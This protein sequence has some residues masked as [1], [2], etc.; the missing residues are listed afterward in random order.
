MPVFLWESATRSFGASP[1]F[2]TPFQCE[3]LLDFQR[4][5]WAFNGDVLIFDLRCC[6]HDQVCKLAERCVRGGCEFN[7]NVVLV[8]RNGDRV[9]RGDACRAFFPGQC[10]RRLFAAVT[11]DRRFELLFAAWGNRTNRSQRYRERLDWSEETNVATRV[12]S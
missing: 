11:C 4:R 12:R 6:D 7:F 9:G 5:G 3:L 10:N 8:G 2:K 1:I